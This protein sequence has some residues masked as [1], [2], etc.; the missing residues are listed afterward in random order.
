MA[1]MTRMLCWLL[2]TPFFLLLPPGGSAQQ[3]VSRAPVATLPVATSPGATF[4]VIVVLDDQAALQGFRAAA[5]ADDRARVHPEAWGYLDHDVVGAVQA[6]EAGHGFHADH[7]YSGVL[8]GFAARLTA[9]QI[10]ALENNPLVAYVEADG[11]MSIVAQ[12][13]P[14]GI[15]RIDAD[16]SSTRA[17]NGSGT[18]SGVNVFIIDTGIAAH[19]DL[20]RVRHVNFAGDGRNTDCNGH[21][22]HVAGTVAAR[23]N[24]SDVVG[25]APGAPLTG[26][27]VLGCNGSGSTSGVIKGVDWVTFNARKPAVANMSLGGGFSRALNDAVLRSVR[28]GVFYAVAAGNSSADACNASPA[29]AGAGTDNGLM[30]TG[31]TDSAD[32]EATFSN[33]G[34]CVDV[35]APGVSVRSTRRGGGTTTFS[36]TSMASPHVAGT[37]ALYL[38]NPAN[39]TATPAEVETALA[40]NARPTE[41]LSE[42]GREISL[43]YA[44]DF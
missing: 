2:I 40:V 5:R 32:N 26:V 38:S 28:S 9:R 15:N 21:G 6:L 3:P 33:F 13:L 36:G 16:L 10:D 11:V 43:I 23:D 18:V 22:T 24:T 14:W 29:S 20:N 44:G 8:R 12:T 30:T 19:A 41:T 27:K 37:A 1:T 39:A 42:D 7:V 34:A 17:G 35:W 25:V 4:P 31:A